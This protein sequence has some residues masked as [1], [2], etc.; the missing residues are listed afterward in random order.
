MEKQLEISV[1]RGTHKSLWLYKKWWPLEAKY[2]Y[3]LIEVTNLNGY[4]Q[5]VVGAGDEEWATRQSEHYGL[6]ILDGPEKG[7]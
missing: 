5:K 4:S 3:E 7:L 2:I 1:K 6:R